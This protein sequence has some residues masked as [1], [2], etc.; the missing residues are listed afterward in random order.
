M[1]KIIINGVE[2]EEIPVKIEKPKEY[3]KLAPL[4][5]MGMMFY[6]PYMEF[7]N[8]DNNKPKKNLLPKDINIIQE[9]ELIELG[10]SKLSRKQRELVSYIFNKTYIKTSNV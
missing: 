1:N 3:K 10:K 8:F 5:Q 6:A 9:F 4:L 2:Y 7:L